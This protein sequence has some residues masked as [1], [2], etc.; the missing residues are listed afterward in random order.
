MVIAASRSWPV[1]VI[2]PR[3]EPALATAGADADGADAAGEEGSGFSGAAP[4]PP[5]PH[6][7]A[8]KSAQP[9]A[10][11]HNRLLLFIGNLLRG[12]ANRL[13]H[14]VS[15]GVERPTP[16]GEDV[17]SDRGESQP[18]CSLALLACGRFHY[19]HPRRIAS[20]NL[21][22]KPMLPGIRGKKLYHRRVRK[23]ELGLTIALT[24]ATVN[25]AG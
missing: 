22:W 17:G 7:T 9:S 21:S 10:R 23:R 14:P 24:V 25:H 5:P 11:S 4:F 18:C 1:K 8:A 16:E 19:T 12:P 3:I 15:G 2:V 20:H 6:P 13:W